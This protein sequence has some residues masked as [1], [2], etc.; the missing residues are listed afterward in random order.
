MSNQKIADDWKIPAGLSAKARAAAKAI[1]KFAF[2]KGLD[3][4]GGP[5]FYSPKQ[6]RER[7]ESYGESCE[8][9]VVY[10]GADI[11]TALSFD[12]A[13]DF[14]SYAPLE[15]LAAELRRLGVYAEEC[16]CWFSGI[17]AD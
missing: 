4:S 1:R 13:Y 7:G 11:R 3:D 8:L 5:I 9:I 17:Y 2:E 10:D 6:W 16:T 14:G 15:E 12:R